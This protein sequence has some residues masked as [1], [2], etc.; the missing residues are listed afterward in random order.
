[1][2][3]DPFVRLCRRPIVNGHFMSG[4]AEVPGD[5]AAHDPEADKSYSCHD[6]ALI[7]VF[8]LRQIG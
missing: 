5:R 6:R 7:S 2:L 1:M 3:A 8:S 4:L